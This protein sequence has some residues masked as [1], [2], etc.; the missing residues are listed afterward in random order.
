MKITKT[1]LKQIIKEEMEKVLR[2]FTPPPEKDRTPG[3]GVSKERT[4]PA[5]P[6]ECS[7]LKAQFDAADAVP[8]PHDD[9][10]LGEFYA[11]M[12]ASE[13]SKRAWDTA[14]KLGC[15]WP[16]EVEAR[17]E[18]SRKKS[19]AD[20]AAR[21]KAREDRKQKSALASKVWSPKERETFAAAGLEEAIREE[22]KKLLKQMGQGG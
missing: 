1:Q 11:H 15:E 17:R 7:K 3:M 10:D 14:K 22:L 16:A 21:W 12:E 20:S 4:R 6:D 8:F 9:R 19:E 2:E 5:S 18:A 13:T